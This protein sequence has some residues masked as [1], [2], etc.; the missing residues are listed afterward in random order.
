[1]NKK[2]RYAVAGLGHI[3]QAAVL[4]AFKHAGE[5]SELTTLL[6]DDPVKLQEV[7]KRYDVKNTYS[8]D[9]YDQA[10][11]SGNFD[12]IY[13]ALPND[14]HKDFTVKAA[15]KGIHVLCEKPMGISVEECL[16]M[17][18]AAKNNDI[19]LMIAYRLHFE[20]ANMEVVKLIQSG[21]IGNPRIFNSSFTMQVRENNIRTQREHGGGPLYDIGI[22][23]INAARYVFKEEPLEV[24]ALF[25]QG[26]DPRFSEV[27]EAVG[28]VLKFPN[29]KI[30]SFV[31]S[32]GS[33]DVSRYE[34]IG[35]EGRVAVEPAYEYVGDLQYQLTTN[36]HEEKRKVPKHDQFAPELLYFSDCVLK[37]V[38]PRPSGYEGLADLRVIEAIQKS[39]Q[40][41]MTVEVEQTPDLTSKPDESMVIEKPAVAKPPI[42]HAK[43]GSIS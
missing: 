17:I 15:N 28:A 24:T 12:A 7:S 39:A 14:L 5:N 2:V 26:K 30:A 35:T 33:F 21:R 1:M 22:Y 9:Q 38:E 25:A 4:P 6:S 3:A 42:V 43:S 13:I 19:R 16:E 20:R 18:D 31:C 36:G 23:C 41:H 32:F 11:S 29:E 37:V 40:T 34:V 10:L 27:E 8:Y